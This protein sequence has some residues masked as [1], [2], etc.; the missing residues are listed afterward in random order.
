MAAIKFTPRPAR[1][2]SDK[3]LF[4]LSDEG[5]VKSDMYTPDY[6][7]YAVKKSFSSE[8]PIFKQDDHESTQNLRQTFNRR[9]SERKLFDQKLSVQSTIASIKPHEFTKQK[10]NGNSPGFFQ[11]LDTLTCGTLFSKFK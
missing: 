4:T 11:L 6:P 3:S 2:V 10:K 5:H 8:I 9:S 7:L 1:K